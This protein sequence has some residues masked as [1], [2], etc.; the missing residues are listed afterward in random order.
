MSLQSHFDDVRV[1]YV[2]QHAGIHAALAW[3]FGI[4]L[5][6]GSTA[7]ITAMAERMHQQFTP[8]MR[9][10]T[11]ALTCG[12]TLYFVVM[13]LLSLSL[14]AAAPW[15]WWSLFGNV[16]T[17]LALAVFFVG[18][19]LLRRWWHPE[20]ERV[21]LTMVLRAWQGRPLAEPR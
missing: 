10:Y 3:S 8:A 4:T 13:L 15:S 17:P 12:W 9:A 1:L 18:E 20:F 2:L 11:R 7:L 5:R 19:H 14:Y 16:L 21:T 6:P